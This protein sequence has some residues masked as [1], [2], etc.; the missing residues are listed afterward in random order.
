MTGFSL[1]HTFVHF[2]AY[3]GQITRKVNLNFDTQIFHET[4]SIDSSDLYFP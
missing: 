1:M 2:D 3:F 4:K